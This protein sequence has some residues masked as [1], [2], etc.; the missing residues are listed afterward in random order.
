ME[1]TDL[2]FMFHAPDMR[3]SSLSILYGH[4]L[5]P[6]GPHL[7]EPRDYLYSVSTQAVLDLLFVATTE[8]RNRGDDTIGTGHLLLVL[9]LEAK[10][11]LLAALKRAEVVDL[12]QVLIALIEGGDGGASRIF[13]MNHVDLVTLKKEI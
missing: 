2:T 6:I 1:H 13:Q 5:N 12:D 7:R 3:L 9:L 4:A 8:C 11:Y 10:G